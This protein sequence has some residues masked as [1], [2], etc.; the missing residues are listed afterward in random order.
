MKKI[1]YIVGVDEVGRGPLAGPITVGAVMIPR[2]FVFRKRKPKDS[3]QLSPKQR[4]EWFL[5]IKDHPDVHCSVSSVSSVVVDNIGISK[6]THL[7]VK[8]S[9]QKLSTTWKSDFQVEV[10]LDGLLHAPK[11]FRQKTIIKGDETV[12]VISLASIVAKVTRDK[13]MERFA[14]KF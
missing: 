8:R 3:K 5:Y 4:E 12:P 14:K 9:L 2:G 10:L 1:R 11:Q 7:A 6:A 13:T